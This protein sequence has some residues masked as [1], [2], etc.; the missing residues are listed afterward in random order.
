MKY[1]DYRSANDFYTID[2]TC[3]ELELSKKELKHYSQKYKIPPKQNQRGSYGFRKVQFC[4]LHNFIYKEQKY[5]ASS[6]P[7]AQKKDPWA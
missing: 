1:I 4:K 3:D 5:G 7:Q 6:A 2:E